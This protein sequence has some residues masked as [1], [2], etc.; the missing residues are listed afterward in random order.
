VLFLPR[1]FRGPAFCG[2]LAFDELHLSRRNGARC[3]PRRTTSNRSSPS[4]HHGLTPPVLHEIDL[5]LLATTSSRCACLGDDRD[6]R[7]AMLDAGVR[8]ARLRTR[9]TVG[10]VLVLWRPNPER[11]K[12]GRKS[13][14]TCQACARACPQASGAAHPVDPVAERRR[15]ARTEE[16]RHERPGQR[17]KRTV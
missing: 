3:A 16:A 15:A 11:K 9:A 5:A 2:I 17:R 14:G 1:G 4:G 8:G 12:K 13:G 10:K 6:A 7:E